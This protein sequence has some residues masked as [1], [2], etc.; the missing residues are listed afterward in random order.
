MS[1]CCLILL[2]LSLI[3]NC[4]SK[5]YYHPI[6]SRFSDSDKN[7]LKYVS[8]GYLGVPYRYGGTGKHGFDCSGFV[9]RV[10]SDALNRKL[11]R[12]TKG[13]FKASYDISV[14]QAQTGDLVFFRIKSGK[15]DHVG[16]MLNKSGFIHTSKSRGVVVSYLGEDYYW[17]R[18]AGIRR[19]R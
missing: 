19:L 5:P 12:T 7:K 1:R 15:L 18:F 8:K 6:K 3:I 14:S 17:K 11:P 10:Y 2:V 9:Y 13:L 4:G 16:M